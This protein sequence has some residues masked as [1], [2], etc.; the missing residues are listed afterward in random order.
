MTL[1]RAAFFFSSALIIII[2]CSPLFLPAHQAAYVHVL[3]RHS[4]PSLQHLLGTDELGRDFFYLLIVGG[5]HTIIT[6]LQTALISAVLGYLLARIAP[7]CLPILTARLVFL[8]PKLIFFPHEKH[9]W[10]SIAARMSVTFY[11]AL[12]TWISSVL[13]LASG[14][15]DVVGIGTT[16]NTILTGT[17]LSVGI[18]YVYSI[19]RSSYSVFQAIALTVLWAAALHCFIE[20]MGFG[21][22]LPSWGMILFAQSSPMAPRLAS[23]AGFLMLGLSTFGIA[24][25]FG[26]KKK[27]A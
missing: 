24:D 20:V 12:L 1:K 10:I 13:A 2:L 15:I 27:N 25:K 17:L 14:L 23:V 22:W 3:E 7:V 4:P 21:V 18:A 6:A 9:R 11:L 5:N 16:S 8:A 26:S 19:D